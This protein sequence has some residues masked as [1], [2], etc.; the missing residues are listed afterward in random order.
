MV[1]CPEQGTLLQTSP[2]DNGALS[3]VCQPLPGSFFVARG[4]GLAYKKPMQSYSRFLLLHKNFPQPR[5]MAF[6]V[7]DWLLSRGVRSEIHS[8]E[9]EAVQLRILAA[10]SDVVLV[11]GGDG[12]MVGIA[13]RLASVNTPMVGMNFGRVGFLAEIPSLNWEQSLTDLLEQR[14]TLERHL[15]LHWQVFSRQQDG[16]FIKNEGVAINDLVTA[17]GVV[18]RAVS[19]RLTIDGVHLSTMRCDGVIVATPLGSTAYNAS[20]GGPL[21]IPSMHAQLVTPICPFAGA[22]P[23][24]TVPSSSRIQIEACR[25]GDEVILSVDGQE[26]LPLAVGDVLEVTGAP[27]Q[28]QMLVSDSSWYLRRLI[29]RGI[30]TSGPDYQTH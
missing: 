25:Q 17:H 21:T 20:A 8:A 11:L 10:A 12:T 30:V 19:L 15:A 3:A 29:E 1:A 27:G 26:N 14:W 9:T 16:W 2:P 18:A 13:R 7:K 28:L 4:H 5:E 6:R 23:P 24:L 22:F